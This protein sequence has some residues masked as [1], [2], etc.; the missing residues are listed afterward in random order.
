MRSLWLCPRLSRN[1]F[2]NKKRPIFW[3]GLIYQI[4]IVKITTW[5]LSG[6]APDWA[7]TSVEAIFPLHLLIFFKDWYNKQGYFW[8][9]QDTTGNKAYKKE[10][11][12][13][14]CTVLKWICTSNTS[15]S[16]FNDAFYICQWRRR[17]WISNS[18][19][20]VIGNYVFFKEGHAC[21]VGHMPQT[22][23][24]QSTQCSQCRKTWQVHKSCVKKICNYLRRKS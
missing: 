9:V 5:D 15:L 4:N 21:R 13:K 20:M 6:S 16:I 2:Q 11:W 14:N 10:V 3:M 1:F 8:E 17:L 23:L 19:R 7:G 24:V 22:E 18:E 12:I